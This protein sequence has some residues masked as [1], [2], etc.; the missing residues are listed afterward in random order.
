MR[1]GRNRQTREPLQ[2]PIYLLILRQH[3]EDIMALDQS[4]D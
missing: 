1:P 2:M 4:G 3:A